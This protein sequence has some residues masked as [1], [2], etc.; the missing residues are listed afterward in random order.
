MKS[1]LLKLKQMFYNY[2]TF[3]GMYV[4]GGV[5]MFLGVYRHSL[6]EVL[7][8]ASFILSVI[9]WHMERRRSMKY[10]SSVKA[11]SELI[12]NNNELHEQTK[13]HHNLIAGL[14]SE[15][16]DLKL[17]LKNAKME[18]ARLRNNGGRKDE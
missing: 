3:V 10:L 8:A 17:K 12:K 16:N 7:L 9:G 1:K 4:T 13:L 2:W 5:S 6:A 14:V 15:R 18:S 11:V